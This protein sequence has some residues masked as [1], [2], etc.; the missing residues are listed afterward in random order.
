MVNSKQGS[1]VRTIVPVRG[2][3][4]SI[5]YLT[6]QTESFPKE[7]DRGT[8]LPLQ[9]MHLIKPGVCVKDGS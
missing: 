6:L 3:I 2:V 4:Y 9:D 1:I 7:P 5:S 8:G